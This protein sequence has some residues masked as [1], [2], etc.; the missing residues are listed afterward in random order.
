MQTALEQHSLEHL[1][2]LGK[3]EVNSVNRILEQHKMYQDGNA[4][5]NT[6]TPPTPH[7]VTTPVDTASIFHPIGGTL[8]AT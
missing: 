1:I 8:P 5:S 2:S 4:A 6:S 3:L 7:S